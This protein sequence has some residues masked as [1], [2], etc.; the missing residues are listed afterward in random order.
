MRKIY[1]VVVLTLLTQA[2]FAQCPSGVITLSSQLAVNNFKT[3]Y[4][5]CVAA[6]NLRLDLNDSG[7]TNL[8]GLSNLTSIQGLSLWGTGVTNLAPLAKLQSASLL[9]IGYNDALPNLT[10]MTALRN[11]G[12]LQLTGG[13]YSNL[14][15]LENVETIGGASIDFHPYL[16]D[17]SALSGVPGAGRTDVFDNPALSNCAIEF[18]CAGV[19]LRPGMLAAMVYFNAPGCNSIGEIAASCGS[20]PVT[21]ANFNVHTEGKMARLTW[22][23]TTESNSSHFE[24]ERSGDGKLWATIGKVL[25]GGSQSSAV[26]YTFHDNAPEAGQNYYRL[27][28]VDLDLTSAY[29]LI[30]TIRIESE[31]DIIFPNPVSDKLFVKKDEAANIAEILIYSG[32]GKKTM[33]VTQSFQDGISLTSLAAGMYVARIVSHSGAIKTYKFIKK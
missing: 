22:T 3:T 2:V 1:C 28:M 4:P 33:R 31:S 23:T 13:Q 8:D 10:G 11:I 16:N 26:Q 27:K 7:I 5:S 30:Q 29:S 32:A 6:T 9:V 20:L 17:I 24:I 14:A 25:A 21:L 18:I 15:G 19:R 12:Y